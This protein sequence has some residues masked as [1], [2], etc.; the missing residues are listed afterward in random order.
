MEFE[1]ISL[2]TH[3]HPLPTYIYG[4]LLPT[5]IHMIT[6]YPLTYTW[7]PSTHWH[8]CDQHLLTNT[9]VT[10]WHIHDY[11]LPTDIYMTTFYPLTYMSLSAWG[12]GSNLCT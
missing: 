7:Q 3:D 2:Y 11:L 12:R 5:Y 10:N 1:L 4:R 8:R 6:L 9:R